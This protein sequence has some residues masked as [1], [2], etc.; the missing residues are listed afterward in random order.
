MGLNVEQQ[1]E[2]VWRDKDGV[3]AKPSLLRRATSFFTKPPDP[4]RRM[5]LKAGLGG[6]ALAATHLGAVVLGLN[7]AEDAYQEGYQ[8]VSA[9]L[10]STKIALAN[11]ESNGVITPEQRTQIEAEIKALYQSQLDELVEQ[12]GGLNE[13]LG[14]KQGTIDAQAATINAPT[15]E[16]T[17]QPAVEVCDAETKR[18]AEIGKTLELYYDVT[19]D[20]SDWRRKSNGDRLNPYVGSGECGGFTFSLTHPDDCVNETLEVTEQPP[21]V[22]TTEPAVPTEDNTPKPPPPTQPAPPTA[23]PAGNSNIDDLHYSGR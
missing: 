17:P 19:H 11:C 9:E 4:G 2:D 18:L 20:G 10:N 15:P 5:L 21:V 16:S 12:N 6:A 22:Q 7:I 13:Q 14:Q 3:R 1:N 8:E 23:V